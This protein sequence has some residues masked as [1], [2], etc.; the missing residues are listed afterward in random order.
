MYMLK[1]KKG[2]WLSTPP[3]DVTQ[4]VTLKGQIAKRQNDIASKYRQ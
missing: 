1:H 4:P 3:N 2:K